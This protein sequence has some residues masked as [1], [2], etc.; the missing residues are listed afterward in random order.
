MEFLL[1][2]H[3]LDCPICD[4]AGECKLQ[5]YAVE[6]GRGYSR[7][8][9]H[10]VE[11]RKKVEFSDRVV[12]D[13]ERCIL[14]TRC[15][16]FC[17]EVAGKDELSVA[18]R[19]DQNEIVVTPGKQ[20]ENDYSMNVIDICPVGAL[21]S[22]DFRFRSRIW[23]MDFTRSVCPTCSR[24]CNIVVGSRENE[25]LRLVPAEN[26]D[27]N[28]HWM[29]D[30]G[31]LTYGYVHEKR[32]DAPRVDGEDTGWEAALEA[33]RSRLENVRDQGESVFGL[34][35]ARLT[36]EELWLARRLLVDVLGTTNL[37]TVKRFGEGD[38]LL[39]RPEKNPN[40]VGAKLVGIA[41]G[42]GSLG[43]DDLPGAIEDGRVK[44]LV[45][46]G[47][48]PAAIPELAAAL[49]KLESLVL[50]H[51]Q[52][53]EA[54]A[55]VVLPGCTTFEKEGTLV[56]FEGRVQRIRPAI[57]P[58]GASRP[59][60]QILRDLLNLLGDEVSVV[61]ARSVFRL[62]SESVPAF[63]GMTVKSLGELGLPAAEGAESLSS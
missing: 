7:F 62:L 14:C 33:A 52:A 26:Q 36:N 40:D 30:E 46:I 44:T 23:F 24:G 58:Q 41:P 35:S 39:R 4:Q 42:D 12:Y 48:D 3:P 18:N 28:R 60:W 56:N 8:D 45:A 57:R 2:N 31:R 34:V 53:S 1:I 47:E 16:R 59:D 50:I 22:K 27:V 5:D 32:L 49:G 43:L 9:E 54:K 63:G 38:D 20:L 55:H 17:A 19:G 51:P 15:V 25:I 10:K 6:H 29:C 61:S 11:K 13:G 21:T 37:D